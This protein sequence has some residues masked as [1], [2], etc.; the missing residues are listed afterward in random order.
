MVGL[1]LN[2]VESELEPV[3]DIQF[4]QLRLCLNQGRDSLP[5]SEAR[6]IIARAC[7]IFE[8]RSIPV[9]GISQLGLQ[10]HPTGWGAHIGD[11]QISGVWTHSD[12]K[13]HISVLELK[14]VMLT[15]QH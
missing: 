2:E 6:M 3:Q 1:K 13:L 5:I 12:R 11:S 4:L 9:H 10:S 7:Q 15:L 8:Q 14:V